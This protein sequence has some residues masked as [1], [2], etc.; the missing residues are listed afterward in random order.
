MRVNMRNILFILLV[1]LFF[2]SI[3]GCFAHLNNDFAPVL[4]YDIIDTYP[5]DT[6]AFTQGLILKDG[7]LYEGTGLYGESSL[8]KVELE[9]G[10]VLQQFNLPGEFFGEGI[11]ILNNKIYQ[12]TWKK[13]TGFIYD[14]KTFRLL[15][16]FTYSHEGW[17]ITHD[18]EYLII[19]DGTESLRYVDAFTFKEI[20]QIDVSDNGQPVL[21][22]NE[23]EYVNNQIYANI[24]QTDRIAIIDPE[25]G[26]VISWLD[27]SGILEPADTSEKTDVLNGIAFDAE[28]GHLL[29][30]GKLWPK[31][32][33]IKITEY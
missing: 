7:F 25:S 17:G 33:R 28:N 8:R 24:W 11:T 10:R 13:Q 23:L 27:L 2:F 19:S 12:L 32:F 1:I 3:S 31:I 5:H 29:I 14:Y 22:L 20:K 18:G 16:I 9:T 26:K 30:T 6:G 4:Q 21:R 15:D